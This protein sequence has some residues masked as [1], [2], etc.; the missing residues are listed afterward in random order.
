MGRPPKGGAQPVCFLAMTELSQFRR[1]TWDVSKLQTSVFGGAR[2]ERTRSGLPFL[3]ENAFTGQAIHCLPA[4][5][6]ENQQSSQRVPLKQYPP[7]N[8]P[9]AA[10]TRSS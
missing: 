1:A 8:I 6:T 3:F 5:S 4:V 2:Y 10:H 9:T 7:N